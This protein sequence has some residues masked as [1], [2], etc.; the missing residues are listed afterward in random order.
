M[1]LKRRIFGLIIAA[2][3][4]ASVSAHAAVTLPKIIGDHMVIQADQKAPIWGKAAPGECV[5]VKCCCD[6]RKAVADADGKWMVRLPISGKDSTI[7]IKDVL[8]G[9]VWVGS[10]QSN[11]Q[12]TVK[13]S[14]NAEKEIA[15]ADYPKMRL[16]YVE[17]KSSQ[18]PQWDCNGEWQVCTPETVPMFSAVLYFFGRDLHKALNRP[19]G[20]IHTSWGGT[21]A[22]SWTS[23]GALEA[24][25]ALAHIVKRTEELLQKYPEAKKD[26]DVKLADWQK[27]ADQAKADGKEAPKRPNEPWGPDHPWCAS[28][29]YNAMIN[30]LLPYGIKGAIWYQGESNADRAYQYRTLFPAMIKDWRKAWGQGNFPFYW[31]QLANFMEPVAEPE[32]CAWAELREAQNMTLSL[33]NT[34]TAVIIDIG[35]AKNIHPKNKQDVGKRLAL[36]AMAQTYDMPVIFSGPMYKSVKFKDGK[37]VVKFKN[38]L[39]LN[40]KGGEPRGFA[41]AGPDRKFYWAKAE[42]KN[43]KVIVWSEKVPNPVA[44]RYGW[45]NNPPC[46]VYNGAGLPASPFRT[47]DWPGITANKK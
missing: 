23:R 19:V 5:T 43:D 12:W 15:E 32:E 25:P 4:L 45:A 6:E 16:F 47:D 42:I 11:M 26:F 28:G 10:G 44:V 8:V 21:P 9:E 40:A 22:E 46:N 33:P 39:G 13:D 3:F 41:I 36:N 20:L 38:G 29:L 7:T 30:P 27:Q 24:N 18:N 17:R 1:L 2:I 37:A 31:V 34:G 14:A 35:E